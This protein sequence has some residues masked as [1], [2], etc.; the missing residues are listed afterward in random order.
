MFTAT[1]R[2]VSESA[3]DIAIVFNSS[4]HKE[5]LRSEERYACEL[6]VMYRA[7]HTDSRAGAWRT[8][9]TYEVSVG[10]FCMKADRCVEESKLFEVCFVLPNDEEQAPVRSEARIAYQRAWA[11]GKV[12][13]GFD[14]TSISARDKMR[15][16]RFM[17]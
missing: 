3:G 17:N 5:Q 8:G 13:V 14:F 10:G 15:I 7:R 2:I 11:D 16:L 9:S 4:L 12:A 6:S 1:A